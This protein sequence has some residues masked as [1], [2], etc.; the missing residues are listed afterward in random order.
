MN[1][2]D[3]IKNLI[4]SARDGKATAVKAGIQSV[5]GFKVKEALVKRENEIAKTIFKE[6]K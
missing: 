4:L 2:R 5:L 3:T 6:K 1:I